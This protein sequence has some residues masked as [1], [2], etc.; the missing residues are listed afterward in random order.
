MFQTEP[1]SV[2]ITI[3]IVAII[4]EIMIGA[5]TGF[6]LFVLGIIFIIAGIIGSLSSI[7]VAIVSIVIMIA[8]YIFVGRRMIKKSLHFISHKTNVESIIG[9]KALVTMAITP[10][11]P[12]RVKIQGEEWRA[13]A[14]KAIDT[15]KKVMINSV[16]GVTLTVEQL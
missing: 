9:K 16:S 1:H 7:T 10:D 8:L 3:G 13:E 15:G 4:I 12:G 2:L 5:A 11:K 14:E 6:E